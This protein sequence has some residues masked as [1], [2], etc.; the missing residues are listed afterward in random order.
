MHAKTPLRLSPVFLLLAA[1]AS[2]PVL[3]ESPLPDPIAP[4]VIGRPLDQL[5]PVRKA[6]ARKAVVGKAPVRQAAS[7]PA[8]ARPSALRQA[9]QHAGARPAPVRV[10]APQAAPQQA[11]AQA[12]LAAPGAGQ[13]TSPQRLAKRAVDDRA[14]PRISVNDVGKGTHFARKPLGPGAYFDDGNRQAVHK[15]YATHPLRTCP[16]GTVQPSAACPPGDRAATW[17]IGQ[18]LPPGVRVGRLPQPLLSSLPKVPPGHEYVQVA[19]DVLLV[20]A[21]SGMVVDGIEAR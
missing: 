20:A 18:T 3:A 14:D 15:Y 19:G 7:R 17:Q 11:A 4:A 6:P 12:G 1:A 13:G 8:G 9:P 10:A 5:Q 16:A 2:S 21:G